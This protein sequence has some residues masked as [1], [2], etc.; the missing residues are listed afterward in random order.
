MTVIDDERRDTDTSV[1]ARVRRFERDG[2]L[3]IPG[4]LS[5]EQDGARAGR[6][7]A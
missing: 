3:I 4:A 7:T 6:A 5:A 2:F 1:E